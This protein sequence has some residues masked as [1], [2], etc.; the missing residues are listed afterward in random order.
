M[1]GPFSRR[2]ANWASGVP[3][4]SGL[5]KK[6]MKIITKYAFGAL[7]AM[8]LALNANAKQDDKDA[9]KDKEKKEKVEVVE[10]LPAPK[11]DKPFSVPDTGSTA[12]L[13]GL[14]VALLVLS[15]RKIARVE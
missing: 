1:G 6:S 2:A 13:L 4:K 3:K 10:S 7:L 14:A 5:S 15:Q 8:A 11:P 12:A 9:K